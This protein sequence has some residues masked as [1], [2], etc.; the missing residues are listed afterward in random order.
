MYRPALS[1]RAALAGSL[2]FVA[3]PLRA[4]PAIRVV[5]SFSILA[6]LVTQI[7]G[8]RVAVTALVGPEH[9]LHGYDP[10]ASDVQAVGRAQ[11]MV[12]NGFNIE[13]WAERVTKSAGFKGTSIVAS[14]GV[15]A[16][17]AGGPNHAGHSHDR[18]QQ[19]PHAW[20]NVANVKLYAG[21]IR[22]G[23]IAADPAGAP[24]YTAAATSLI[25]RLT[26]LDSDIRSA[27][28]PI[29]RAARTVITS[30]DAFSYYGAAYDID[31]LAPQGL[32]TTEEP[33]PR[34][35]A[36]LIAQVKAKN[37]RAL[38]LEKLGRSPLLQQVSRETGVVIGGE[39][40]SDALSVPSGPA[41][42]YETMMRHNTR[43][44]S[45]ALRG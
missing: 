10:R 1:R 8:D 25:D 13:P 32:S 18:G 37:A 12:I 16:L 7:G 20:Q 6:D 26:A 41:A 19:D 23:L 24:A 44:I 33:T 15:T 29:P 30:H 5:A 27:Y 22:D 14:R 34:Q 38:F 31:F 35:I 28:L 45:E 39:L 40:Y 9:D 4:A 43:L 17:K 3:T 2:A 42:T 11:A 36:T 21:N